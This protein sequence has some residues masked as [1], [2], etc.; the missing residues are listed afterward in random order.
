MAKTT[1]TAADD[2]AM[3]SVADAMRDAATTASEHAAQV[4]Q[5]ASEAGPRRFRLSRTPFTPAPTSW[6]MAS[7]MPRC[8]LLSRCPRRTR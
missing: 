3:R 7:S 2:A 1:T 6:R 8:L 4:K 5:S